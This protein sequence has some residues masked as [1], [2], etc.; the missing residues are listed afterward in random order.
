MFSDEQIEK[1]KLYGK[2]S[3]NN[4]YKDGYTTGIL[5]GVLLSLIS[6][7]TVSIVKQKH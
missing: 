7:L 6:Y 4:G 3:Y 5:S 2:L 1:I